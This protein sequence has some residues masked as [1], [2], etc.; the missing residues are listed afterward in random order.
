LFTQLSGQ[1][2]DHIGCLNPDGSLDGAFDPGA[3]DIVHALALQP[4]GKILVGGDFT[5]LNGL[6]HNNIGRLNPDGSLDD[7]FDPLMDKPV[8]TLT[9]QPDGKILVGG[10][11][12]VLDSE[13]HNN[14][15][16][17]NPDGSLDATF[18]PQADGA[19]HTIA[20]QADGKI[21]VGGAFTSMAG[22]PRP[23]L[24]RLNPDSRLDTAFNP[25]ANGD[26]YAL[27]L[28]A[29]G[30]LLAGGEFTELDDLPRSKIGRLSNLT[31]ALQSLSFDAETSTLTWL[32]HGASPEVLRTQFELST[33]G[34]SYTALGE[35]VR[36]PG[37]WQLTGVTLPPN[38]TIGGLPRGQNLFIRLRGDYPSGQS[39]ASSS[40]LQT[41]YNLHFNYLIYLPLIIRFPSPD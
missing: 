15:A 17:L 30:K 24:A 33:D 21:I 7:G 9:L 4:D 36:I 14:L 8:R 40:A 29:D 1:P 11:F 2:R 12:T 3:D 20:L 10:D 16:R 22:Q 26:V 38:E 31:A 25:G 39:N 27:A 35:G 13:P 18:D 6:Q 32:R 23:R 41:V 34:S 37:G 5:N 28:Q 19:V